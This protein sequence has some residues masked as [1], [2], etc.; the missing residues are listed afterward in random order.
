VVDLNYLYH[1]Q[2]VSL[3]RSENG[4]CTRSRSAHRQLATA[5][6]RLIDQC[7]GRGRRT[8]GVKP[9]S[10]NLQRKGMQT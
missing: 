3:F 7:K 5:Y 6:E 2:Q 4:A 8:S 10:T 9:K 1:R